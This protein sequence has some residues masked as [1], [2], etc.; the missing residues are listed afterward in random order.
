MKIDSWR[1]YFIT[2]KCIELPKVKRNL[3]IEFII[4]IQLVYD[5]TAAST[6]KIC[7]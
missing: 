1:N 7:I 4:P 2:Q 3:I 5:L 6:S